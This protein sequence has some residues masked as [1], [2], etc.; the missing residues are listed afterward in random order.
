MKVIIYGPNRSG[1]RT[2][3]KRVN[4]ETGCATFVVDEIFPDEN[5]SVDKGTLFICMGDT[6]ISPIELY[7]MFAEMPCTSDDNVSMLEC[8]K[9]C[10]AS[11]RIN[12][13]ADKFKFKFFDTSKSTK[14]S[15]D[16]IVAY[17]KIL[18]GA[19]HA[20]VNENL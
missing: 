7:K 18:L 4:E 2:I 12:S 3:A 17:V 14:N 16:E 1:R 8:E 13:F 15:F 5:F 19:P 20:N 10:Q 11:K 9:I 6:E